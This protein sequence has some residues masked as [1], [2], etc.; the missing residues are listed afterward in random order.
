MNVPSASV[1]ASITRRIPLT[2]TRTLTGTPAAIA[3]VSGSY[4][5]P[6]IVTG[7]PCGETST[8]TAAVAR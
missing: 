6:V 4:A 8:A 5:R 3:P 1:T 7:A 2:A